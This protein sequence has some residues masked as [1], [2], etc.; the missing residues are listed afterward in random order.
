M[1]PSFRLILGVAL[2]LL[3]PIAALGAP[4]HAQ[5]RNQDHLQGPT[6]PELEGVPSTPLPKP[7]TPL[8]RRRRK[9]P[10]LPIR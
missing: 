1:R 8:P 5:T 4:A 9:A 3:G 10:G 7:A 2:F 6:D